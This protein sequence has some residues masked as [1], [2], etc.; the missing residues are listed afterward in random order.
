MESSSN[1][2]NGD[3]A[4]D[5][6]T[7]RAQ[8]AKAERMAARQAQQEARGN[9]TAIMESL[10]DQAQRLGERNGEEGERA[11]KQLEVAR[12]TKDILEAQAR[13]SAAREKAR[14]A[15][16]EHYRQQRLAAEADRAKKQDAQLI[17]KRRQA[18]TLGGLSARIS[19]EL[20]PAFGP[21]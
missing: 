15:R 1:D 18:C 3:A 6:A 10:Q 12:Q 7:D 14:D 2:G 19:P 13:D 5:D 9:V 11:E 17:E 21:T 16:T 8:Q 4:R 20:S